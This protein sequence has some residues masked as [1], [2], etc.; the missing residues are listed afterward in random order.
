M[1][2]VTVCFPN[3]ESHSFPWEERRKEKGEREGGRAPYP[4]GSHST[5]NTDKEPP[6]NHINWL[7]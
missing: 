7:Q 2:A 6:G 4:Q 5:W 1:L 3:L